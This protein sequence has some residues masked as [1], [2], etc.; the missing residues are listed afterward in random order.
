VGM[1]VM[2]RDPEKPTKTLVGEVLDVRSKTSETFAEI[3]TT[4]GQTIT[5]TGDHPFYLPQSGLWASLDGNGKRKL[6]IGSTLLACSVSDENSLVFDSIRSIQW[7]NDDHGVTVY[8]LTVSGH[9]CHF[10]QGVL[11]HNGCKQWE[12][13]HT[14]LTGAAG[15][16]VGGI[17]GLGA[18]AVASNYTQNE[19][20]IRLTSHVSAYAS[21]GAA[22]ALIGSCILPGLGTILGATAGAT[23]GI[24]TNNVRMIFYKIRQPGSGK[25]LQSDGHDVHLAYLADD[26]MRKPDPFFGKVED[27]YWHASLA[28]VFVSAA[29]KVAGVVA[30]VAVAE[31]AEEAVKQTA[32]QAGKAAQKQ[33]YKET[34]KQASKEMS[35]KSARDVAK[36]ASKTAGKKAAQESLETAAKAAP[37]IGLVF[38]IASAVFRTC[39]STYQLANG[40]M[41]GKG[42]QR[43]WGWQVARSVQE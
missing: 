25:G 4:S 6:V 31:A 7:F 41:T 21:G 15:A 2:Q 3:V 10:I 9:H 11:A 40:S 1:R 16:V 43:T 5:C 29:T 12:M 36:V 19:L 42:I 18:E 22:G 35:K 17:V 39:T 37:G 38:G 26:H 13:A 28:Q 30:K 24:L 23:A 33:V 14:L 20:K 27:P 32:K 34:F 8:S